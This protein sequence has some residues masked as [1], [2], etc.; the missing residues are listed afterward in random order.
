VPARKSSPRS[1]LPFCADS[2][3]W[4]GLPHAVEYVDHYAG[5]QGACRAALKMLGDVRAVLAVLLDEQP[6]GNQ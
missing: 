4:L 1:S 6:G 2:K 5:A 3:G